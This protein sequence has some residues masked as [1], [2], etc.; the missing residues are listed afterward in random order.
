MVGMIVFMAVFVALVLWAC[1]STS[2]RIS[3]E[4]EWRDWEEEK[5]K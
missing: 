3:R 1:C 5:R 2:G 4:E